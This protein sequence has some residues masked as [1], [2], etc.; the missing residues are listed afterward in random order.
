VRID[1]ASPG[2]RRPPGDDRAEELQRKIDVLKQ[3]P[4]VPAPDLQGDHSRPQRHEVKEFALAQPL[5]KEGMAGEEM[6]IL[7]QGKVRVHKNDAFITTCCRARTSARWRW[8][9]AAPAPPARPPRSKSRLLI[10]RARDFY[11]IV[12]KDPSLSVKLLWS[13]VQVLADR[14]RKTTA[15]LSGARLEAH[16]QDMTDDVLFDDDAE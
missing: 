3:M 8:S 15:E 2:R 16:A 4:H 6:F 12:R 5:I 7:L 10:L 13:F 14:L 11:E 9:I 1:R